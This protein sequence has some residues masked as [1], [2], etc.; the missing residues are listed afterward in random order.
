MCVPVFVPSVM[1]YPILIL[2]IVALAVLFTIIYRT[3]NKGLSSSSK[4]QQLTRI[5]L[6]SVIAMLPWLVAGIIPSG[7]PV[8][9]TAVVSLLWSITYPLLYNIT[10][11][12]RS[13]E[14]DNQMD[15]V[16]GLYSFGF[17]SA[18]QLSLDGTPIIAGLVSGAVEAV[19]MA[20]I[21]SQWVYYLLYKECVDFKGMTIVQSTNVN[22]VIEFARSFSIMGM[23][24][25]LLLLVL[26]TIAPGVLNIF[27][28]Y[29][30]RL[31]P[32]WVIITEGV[33]AVGL[34]V[35]IFVGKRSP[36]R[37]C[38]LLSLY[39][40]ILE[41][42][43]QNDRYE[44]KSYE[45][46]ASLEVSQNVVAENTPRTIIMVIGESANRDYMSA[47]RQLDRETTPWL[48][49]LKKESNTILF[50]NA[51]SC[52]M[53]TV[54]SLERALTE[55]NQYN[56][57]PFFDSV[58]II[59]IAHKSGYKV[60]WYS[61][62][63][64]LGAF[65]TPVTLVANSSD[66]AKWTDQQLNKV[67]YDE[68]L[69]KFL[70]EV[71]PSVNN[72]VVVHLKGSHFNFANRYPED[73]AVWLPRKG[74]DVNVINYLNSIHYTDEVLR[75]IYEYGRERL[76]LE[77]MVYFSDHATYPDRTRTPGFI[78]FGMIRIPLFVWLSDRYSKLHPLRD[79]ALRDNAGKYFTND[80][81]YELMCGIFDVESD[82]FDEENS[83]ASATYKFTRDMLLTYDGK[84]RIADDTTDDDKTI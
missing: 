3:V 42:R 11:R 1:T 54:N 19:M 37:R 28:G 40:T 56:D 15:I 12:H 72:F 66:V 76:H 52:A 4:H 71:D 41:Y 38:G 48:S 50:P 45:R 30:C 34:C 83:I 13:S 8:I 61:N 62:Q 21:L 6:A 35:F 73:K 57:K 31:L 10:N 7:I 49:A 78:G 55:R 51:Y 79:K 25:V 20:L 22:E 64:H 26:V 24:G 74:E 18:L 2:I 47:F 80:L 63:G 39:D 27:G 9:V 75:R 82:H 17:I 77:A 33:L 70:D 5:S 68:T 29:Y 36:L 43:R 69:L 58:S 59:D 16:F 65:D 67:P 23:L 60:H 32:L 44:E 53:V 14:Y 81:V 46:Y 84:V